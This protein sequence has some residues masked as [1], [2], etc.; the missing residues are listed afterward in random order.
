MQKPKIEEQ[1]ASTVR[2]MDEDGEPMIGS[3]GRLNS[4]IKI[5]SAKGDLS[6]D[7]MFQTEVDV[8]TDH[9]VENPIMQALTNY[10]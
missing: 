4:G 3:P 10:R 2:I 1:Q 7:L 9:A 5:D 6:K 8:A